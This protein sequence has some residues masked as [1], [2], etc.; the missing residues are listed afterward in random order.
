MKKVEN[1]TKTEIKVV[2][3][4]VKPQ[5][6]FVKRRLHKMLVGEKV[7][8]ETST[9]SKPEMVT[10]VDEKVVSKV[11]KTRDELLQQMKKQYT[12]TTPEQFQYIK[13]HLNVHTQRYLK[14]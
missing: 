5:I 7:A 3:N 4:D 1:N 14:A 12:H 11:L 10:G 6:Y 13:N 2:V 8:A 9:T